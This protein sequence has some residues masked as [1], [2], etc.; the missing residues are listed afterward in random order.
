MYAHALIEFPATQVDGELDPRAGDLYHPGDEVP[1]DLPGLDELVE[2]G[3]VS[4]KPWTEDSEKER[5][6]MLEPKL[7]A[8]QKDEER[9][10]AEEARNAQG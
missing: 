6:A 4:D 9:R 8:W 2:W 7:A 10:I 3:S 1:D 5:N